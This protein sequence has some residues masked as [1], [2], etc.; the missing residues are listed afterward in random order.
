MST[1]NLKQKL[2]H[3]IE[4]FVSAYEVEPDLLS[5]LAQEA[6]ERAQNP[7]LVHVP[8]LKNRL[9]ELGVNPVYKVKNQI[10]KDG[11]KIYLNRGPQSVSR[12][13][14]GTQVSPTASTYSTQQTIQAPI[15]S[16]SFVR[17][18]AW[19]TQELSNGFQFSFTFRRPVS[20]FPGTTITE[21]G[22]RVVEGVS[23]SNLSRIV[24]PSGGLPHT[25]SMTEDTLAIWDIK[26]IV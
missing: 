22:L 23:E 18:G 5:R 12:I 3:R 8:W 9:S 24:A 7:D 1:I 10:L 6:D 13:V 2:N 14:A 26:V 19:E 21:M 25:F 20:S 16:L 11:L 4:G 15:D 17:F